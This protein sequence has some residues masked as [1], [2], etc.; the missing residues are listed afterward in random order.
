MNSQ[1]STNRDG[2][3]DAAYKIIDAHVHFPMGRIQSLEEIAETIEKGRSLGVEKFWNLGDVLRHGPFPTKEQIE[4]INNL[5][6]Q[7]V[8]TFPNEIVA[9]CFINPA[10]D[11]EFIKNEIERC[12]EIEAFKGIKLE[13]SL[14]CRDERLNVIM[15]KLLQ[16]RAVLVHH[17]WYLAEKTQKEASEPHDVA[18]LAQK[19][20]EAKIVLAHLAGCGIRGVQDI[21][22]C[23]NVMIDTS[24]GQPV[25]GLVEYAVKELGA[26][27][28]L[29]GSD[30]P[31]RDF[32]CQ[33]GRVMGADI[34]DSDKEL[35]LLKNAERIVKQGNFPDNHGLKNLKRS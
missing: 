9:F 20:P 17:S 28:V 11:P 26:D 35:I 31:G 8:E 5:T 15:E 6:I 24:G 2:E 25:S 1:K 10:L 19:F 30:I 7:T 22:N 33:L 16:K 34:S 13:I 4:E 32:S 12:F 27:R 3:S 23:E 14:N 29:Y 18:F 21:K